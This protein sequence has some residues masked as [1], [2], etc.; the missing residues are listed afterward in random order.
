MNDSPSNSKQFK[1]LDLCNKHKW[2]NP[3]TG[4]GPLGNQYRGRMFYEGDDR[5]EL[6]NLLQRMLVELGSGYLNP[7]DIDGKFGN[8]TERAIKRFQDEHKDFKGK[9]LR[10][11]GLVG[12]RTADALNRAMVGRW[13]DFYQ[14]PKELTKETLLITVSKNS[15]KDSISFDRKNVEKV[16]VISVERVAWIDLQT[17]DELGHH[18]GNV[19]LILRLSDGTERKI[20]TD[21]KGYHREER[22]PCGEIKV[23]LPD[24]TT[25]KYIKG[26]KET[27]AILHTSFAAF[28]ITKI[29]AV[30]NL[31]SEERQEYQRKRDLY[32]RRIGQTK[33][34]SG[35]NRR[36]SITKR[37]QRGKVIATG[38]HT[39]QE[40]KVETRRS[41][42]LA[43]DNLALAAGLDRQNDVKTTQ[44]L[45]LLKTWLEDYHPTTVAQGRGYI[46]LVYRRRKEPPHQI[47][48][49]D[50]NH[51]SL[52]SVSIKKTLIGPIGAY[53]IFEWQEGG[54][55][56]DMTQGR[57]SP[58]E[59]GRES[60]DVYIEDIL[61]EES[62]KFNKIRNMNPNKLLIFY[63]LGDMD[64][65]LFAVFNG[66]TG[67]LEPYGLD[68]DINDHIH[69]RN[70]RTIKNVVR[71]YNAAIKGYVGKVR[72][73]KS[74]DD[75]RK[76]GPPPSVYQFP[77]PLGAEGKIVDLAQANF[78]SSLPAWQA[79]AGQLDKLAGQHEEG[80]IFFRIDIELAASILNIFG[81]GET[82]AK[83]KFNA[84]F[85]TDGVRQKIDEVL[86]GEAKLGLKPGKWVPIP[87]EGGAE[88][89]V[90]AI[91]GEGK[92][93]Y[94]LKGGPAGRQWGFEVCDDGTRKVLGPYGLA[95]QFNNQTGEFGYGVDLELPKDMG[96]VNLGIFFQG[97]RKDTLL[98]YFSRAPGFFERRSV[99]ELL[100]AETHWNDLLSDEQGR[101][102]ILGWDANNAHKHK[103]QMP[104]YWDDKHNM[105]LK[106]FPAST[107]KSWHDLDAGQQIAARALGIRQYDWK[108]VW[109][110][111][112]K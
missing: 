24:G 55:F 91:T 72:K 1:P 7:W 54:L 59:K 107:T 9:L 22:V 100:S 66:G 106:E 42:C 90:S 89:E 21:A 11:D 88:Y 93:C 77:I 57:Y 53:S 71:L 95:A 45:R 64:Q 46:V 68:K 49:Y 43:V 48:I 51:E 56:I 109:S 105:P 15:F 52:G 110:K 38:E 16:K 108:S 34:I 75:I 44:L 82:K 26:N 23:I 61:T 2:P 20:Q 12:P 94:K 40:S 32:E 96:K 76:E 6:V 17:V 84:D 36:L 67:T 3:V 97:I 102:Q 33:T 31:T 47:T 58:H 81:F 14:T 60:E 65:R 85:G 86:S 4:F 92:T 35:R 29:L 19:E 99:S 69:D 10:E 50:S 13:Y 73:A 18:V 70:L 103:R 98:A 104:Q 83:V 41:Y 39:G 27:D 101:L 80:A 78:A 79:I 37:E 87:I 25:A 30:H 112:A 111:I 8:K 28:A 62:L 74:E 5:E 63:C